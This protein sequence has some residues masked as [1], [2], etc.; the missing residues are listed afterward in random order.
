MPLTQL[1]AHHLVTLAMKAVEESAGGTDIGFTLSFRSPP[2]IERL[3]E[4]YVDLVHEEAALRS[5][6][7]LDAESG[8]YR[9]VALPETQ[10]RKLLAEERHSISEPHELAAL[11]SRWHKL[12]TDLPVRLFRLHDNRFYLTVQHGLTDAVGGLLWL[13]RILTKYG[14]KRNDLP[15][16]ESTPAPAPPVEALSSG[17]A[18][19]RKLWFASFLLK[20]LPL[21]YLRARKIVDLTKK[22]APPSVNTTGYTLGQRVLSGPIVTT[23]RKRAWQERLTLTQLLVGLTSELLLKDAPAGTRA[24]IGLPISLRDESSHGPQERLVHNYVQ[25][26]PAEIVAGKPW[27]K[28][29]VDEYR[30]IKRGIPAVIGSF[31]AAITR[32]QKNEQQALKFLG[33]H[34][35]LRHADPKRGYF[36]QWSCLFS[37]IESLPDPVLEHY[38]ESI[39]VHG[40][41]EFMG[42]GVITAQS[43]LTIDLCAP[44][45]I[46]PPGI[47]EQLLTDL[48]ARLHEEAAGP[49]RTA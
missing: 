23:L 24:R 8:G 17:E 32:Q 42:F 12:D 9:F 43:S 10:W 3:Y 33:Q 11:V 30:W 16:A 26:F 34:L 2:D 1:D 6:L 39:S 46:Y 7:R 40:K 37:S 27:Q 35:P 19:R 29:L 47:V 20:R 13:A 21:G 44:N 49:G 22:E 38:L 25:T 15:A 14:E 5:V 48:V 31:M 36:L 45:H 4:S 41:F 18:L 28:Q